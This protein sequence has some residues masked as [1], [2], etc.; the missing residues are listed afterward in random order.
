MSLPDDFLN[1]VPTLEGMAD[2]FT[3]A[4]TEGDRLHVDRFAE[5]I[6]RAFLIAGM[7]CAADVIR[8]LIDNHGAD[9]YDVNALLGRWLQ[10]ELDYL[11]TN[12]LKRPGTITL[13]GSDRN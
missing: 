8:K 13:W 10:Q 3:N 5:S 11:A 2:T 9:I 7:A 4:M 12:P 1:A 6:L